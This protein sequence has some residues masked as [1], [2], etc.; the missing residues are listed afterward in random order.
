MRGVWFSLRRQKASGKVRGMVQ[1]TSQ[2]QHRN[3]RERDR[4]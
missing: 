4:K 3:Y 1:G 2:L